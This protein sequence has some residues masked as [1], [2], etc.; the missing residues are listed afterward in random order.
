LWA[1]VF[2]PLVPLT[3]MTVLDKKAFDSEDMQAETSVEW[4]EDWIAGGRL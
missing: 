1:F 3:A 2:G 4:P